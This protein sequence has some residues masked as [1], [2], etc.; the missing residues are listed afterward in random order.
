LT[1]PPPGVEVRSSHGVLAGGILLAVLLGLAIV[2]LDVGSTGL[3]RLLLLLL[4]VL[5]LVPFGVAVLRQ[6]PVNLVEPIY[7]VVFGYALFLFVR[8]LYILAFD[9][10]ALINRMGSDPGKIPVAL[11]L[12]SLGLVALYAGYYSPIGSAVADKL[13]G[14]GKQASPRRLRNWGLFLI[15]LGSLLYSISLRQ[16]AAGEPDAGSTAYFYLGIDIVGVGILFLFYW[17]WLSP[18][19]RRILTVTALLLFF[20]LAATFLASR[21]RILYLGFALLVSYYLL[22]NKPFR[23]RNLLLLLPPALIYTAG[24]GALRGVESGERRV[25]FANLSQ[26]DLQ[27]ALQRFFS[28]AGDLNIFDTYVKIL[29]VVP[30][31]FPYLVPGRTFAYLFVAFVPR[32]L[33]PDKPLTTEILVNTYMIGAYGEVAAGGTGYAY[34]LPASFYLEGGVLAILVGM[35]LFGVFCRTVWSYHT[36]HNTTGS[37]M[38]LA[39]TLPIVLLYQRGGFTDNDTVW[40]LTYLVPVVVGLR[41]ATVKRWSSRKA[42]TEG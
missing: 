15:V 3:S 35:L 22:K 18:R 16:R 23:F 13:P 21:Y 26:F 20:L 8:P 5:L 11:A 14:A 2:Y 4:G 6:K 30:D 7:V 27:Y 12:A 40:Y 9:D 42:A 38:L 36:K 25:T 39:A 32:A 41:Y 29:T 34:S 17:N 31:V 28:S 1:I 10:F 24:V 37:K 33:W 19:W